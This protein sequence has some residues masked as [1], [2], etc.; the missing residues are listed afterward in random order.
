M[1][2]L[3]IKNLRGAALEWKEGFCR[4]Q[5]YQNIGTLSAPL[6]FTGLSVAWDMFSNTQQSKGND[7]FDWLEIEIFSLL[8]LQ[9]FT[10]CIEWKTYSLF[11]FFVCMHNLRMCSH[12]CYAGGFA[13]HDAAEHHFLAFAYQL[14]RLI[15]CSGAHLSPS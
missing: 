15:A 5:S 12:E 1:Y 9:F 14:I 7:R 8:Q 13:S 10:H 2:L 4:H 11:A 3:N 6:V